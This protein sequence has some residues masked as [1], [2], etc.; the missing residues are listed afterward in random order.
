MVRA[1]V[2]WGVR[3][4]GSVGAVGAWQAARR[5]TRRRALTPGPSPASGRGV[6][7]SRFS[8][9]ATVSGR[10][11]NPS[12]LHPSP[13]CGRGDGGE[14]H[15]QLILSHRLLLPLPILAKEVNSIAP[16]WERAAVE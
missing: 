1:K 8:G 4:M 5:R 14:G 3:G 12:N 13:T 10:S 9:L 16:R 11:Q 2:V 7:I 6:W 15:P